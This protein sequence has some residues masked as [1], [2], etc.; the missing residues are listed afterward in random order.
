MRKSAGQD[1]RL[2]WWVELLFVQ[3]GLPDS[4]LRCFLKK[5]R[6]ATLFVKDNKNNIGLTTLVIILM[7]YTNPLIKQADY[8]NK[9]MTGA[10]TYV[11]SKLRLEPG[12]TEKEIYA[13]VYNYCNGGNI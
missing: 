7:A 13:L 2:P 6:K 5:R 1:K 11:T 8:H 10:K 4:W 3:L 12:V 9:C